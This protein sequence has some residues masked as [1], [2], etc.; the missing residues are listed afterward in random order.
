MTWISPSLGAILR[1]FRREG[2]KFTGAFL[3]KDINYLGVI[4]GKRRG[5]KEGDDDRIG[6][7][8]VMR[9]ERDMCRRSLTM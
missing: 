6:S 5:S 2:K 3:P 8:M 4:K 7:G 1:D 9:T